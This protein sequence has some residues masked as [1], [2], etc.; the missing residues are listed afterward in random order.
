MCGWVEGDQ[1]PPDPALSHGSTPLGRPRENETW[2][3][4][5]KEGRVGGT[6][7]IGDTFRHDQGD[8]GRTQVGMQ[9]RECMGRKNVP[10]EGKT[11]LGSGEY[12]FIAGQK[13]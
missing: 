9:P 12:P 13:L 4:G 6:G 10:R 5:R 8:R 2:L 7:R 1:D 3:Q 11:F